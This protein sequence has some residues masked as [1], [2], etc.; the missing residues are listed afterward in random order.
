M[1]TVRSFLLAALTVFYCVENL[2][3]FYAYRSSTADALAWI[4]KQPTAHQE[5]V[6]IDFPEMNITL[7]YPF[8]EEFPYKMVLGSTDSAK[9]AFNFAKYIVTG[10]SKFYDHFKMVQQFPKCQ[11][12]DFSKVFS[13]N[14]ILGLFKNVRS[15]DDLK[16][17]FTSKAWLD[18]LEQRQHTHIFMQ[19]SRYEPVKDTPIDEKVSL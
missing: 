7:P 6:L 16:N 15:F 11:A 4:A 12:D 19:L 18:L 13:P 14:N 3:L 8:I 2:K 9:P 1:K 17:I 10:K 5:N